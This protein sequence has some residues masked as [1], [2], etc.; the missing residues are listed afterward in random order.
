MRIHV[1]D[2]SGH[3]FTEELSRYLAG[4]GHQVVHGYSAQFLSPHGHLDPAAARDLG[5]EVLPMRARV[6]FVRYSPAG[7][8][9]YEL[10]Y[11]GVWREHL[12]RERPDVVLACGVPLFALTRMQRYFRRAGLPWVLWHQDIYSRAI[13]DEA[14]RA[15]PARAA[16]PARALVRRMER[17]QLDGADRVVAIDEAF[18]S[19]YRDWGLAA[20]RVQVL[21]N[22]APLDEIM[23]GADPQP[24]LARNAVPA[25]PFRLLYAG[26][27]G[28]KHQP[29]LLVDL[30]ERVRAAGVDAT[31]VVVSEGDA[32][33]DLAAATAGRDDVT[34]LPFQPAAEVSRMFASADVCV[35]LLDDAAAQ[36]SVPS[37]VLSYL[38]AGRPTAALVP[39]ENSAARVVTRAGGCAA[40]P[41]PDGVDEVARWIVALAADP[42]AAPERAAAARRYAEEH[43]DI[44]RIGAAFE[45]TLA[46][47]VAGVRRPGRLSLATGS[48]GYSRVPVR[49]AGVADDGNDGDDGD[50]L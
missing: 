48:R 29:L 17:T 41:T 36:F 9:R 1:H 28:R 42:D 45:Q 33:D 32:A 5:Y 38:A 12:T 24:W 46:E 30:L 21:P 44:A 43:F 31:L 50:R 39:R 22:W 7:R 13:A 6:P 49:P 15:L 16:A 4:R 10:S 11:A 25:S 34:V 27:L 2:H 47:A 40:P 14:T 20:D 8:L 3:F 19:V 23:P 26:T 18:L 35:A 37:K